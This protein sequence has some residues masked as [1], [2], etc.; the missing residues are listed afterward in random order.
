MA[1]APSIPANV[2]PLATSFDAFRESVGELPWFEC[3]GDPTD[4]DDGIIRLDDWSAVPSPE[5]AG[6]DFLSTRYMEWSEQIDQLMADRGDYPQDDISSLIFEA[7][8]QSVDY[9]PDQDPYHAPNAA[10]LEACYVSELIGKHIF[11]RAN[12]PAELLRIWSFYAIGHWPL[13]YSEGVWP[14]DPGN[15][16]VF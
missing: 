2:D 6:R 15:L 9:K 12:P 7:A 5:F 13:G 14:S 11:V 10:V 4:W 1:K 16:M 3:V 8:S